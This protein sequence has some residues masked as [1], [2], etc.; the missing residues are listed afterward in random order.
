MPQHKTIVLDSIIACFNDYAVD[1]RGDVGSWVRQE[2][3]EQLLKYVDL[4]VSAGP[5]EE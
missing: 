5:V 4:I 2:A 1:K 3:M